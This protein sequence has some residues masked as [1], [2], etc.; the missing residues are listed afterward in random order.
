MKTIKIEKSV[1]ESIL[2]KIQETK[3]GKIAEIS[4]TKNI[5]AIKKIAEELKIKIS[6][7][8]MDIRKAWSDLIVIYN[9][10]WDWNGYGYTQYP[11]EAIFPKLKIK[12]FLNKNIE[13]KKAAKVLSQ[14]EI[15][16]RRVRRLSKLTWITEE[17][18]RDI[19]EEKK[20]YKEDRIDMMEAR[21]ADH[22][23]RKREVLIN[24]M[25]RENPLRYIKDA[26]HAEYILEASNRHNNTDYEMRLDEA[27][28]KAEFGE[29]DKSEIKEYARSN[30]R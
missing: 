19:A 8:Y 14:E 23:S 9:P 12:N 24:K 11:K 18:A 1:K 2:T 30:F 26:E 29:I 10:V 27:R 13:E 6:Y 15:E 25:Y 17:E 16:T 7:D 22:Y 4:G 21:Q 3:K 5:N 20:D 28:E